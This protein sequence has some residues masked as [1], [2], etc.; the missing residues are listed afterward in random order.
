MNMDTKSQAVLEA[1]LALPEAERA[2][3]AAELL[4]TLGHED[5]TLADHELATELE[6]RLE[7][8]RQ[9]PSATIPWSVLKETP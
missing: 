3:I 2:E 4:A 1:A 7:E 5:A 6:R 8:C 9:D